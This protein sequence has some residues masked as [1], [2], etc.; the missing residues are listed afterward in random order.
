M[1]ID[2]V[3]L[4]FAT[5][6]ETALKNEETK[7]TSEPTW[8]TVWSSICL[9]KLE[10][11]LSTDEAVALQTK[12]VEVTLSSLLSGRPVPTDE[13][14]NQAQ[15]LRMFLTGLDCT[16][17]FRLGKDLKVILENIRAIITFD[18]FAGHTREISDLLKK[19]ERGMLGRRVCGAQS[20]KFR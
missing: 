1:Q 9:T 5:L 12:V 13:V 17:R 20:N 8:E 19:L 6:V 10:I 11:I 2:E 7:A 4:N 3:E 14:D 16:A 15:K 18:K